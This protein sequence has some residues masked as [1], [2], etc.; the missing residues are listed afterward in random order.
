MRR[1]PARLEKKCEASTKGS[2]IQSARPVRRAG[3]MGVFAE[4]S[5]MKPPAKARNEARRGATMLQP[6]IARRPPFCRSSRRSRT[7]RKPRRR[8]AAKNGRR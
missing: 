1:A 3:S 5:S 2:G 4:S 7:S 8:M 6:R